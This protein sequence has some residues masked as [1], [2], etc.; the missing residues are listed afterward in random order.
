MVFHPTEKHPRG[1]SGDLIELRDGR[2]MY[3]YSRFLNS[4]SDFAHSDLVARYS[5]DG[6][7]TWTTLDQMVVPK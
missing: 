5:A 7:L 4:G 1:G 3:L 6:G 2:I